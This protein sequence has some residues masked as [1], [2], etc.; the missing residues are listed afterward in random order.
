[1]D[2]MGRCGLFG[3][4]GHPR[5]SRHRSCRAVY[6]SAIRDVA[7]MAFTSSD[8]GHL[9]PCALPVQ[10][11]LGWNDCMARLSEDS[12]RK[13][14]RLPVSHGSPSAT[15][16]GG[17]LVAA[18]LA[19]GR[20]CSGVCPYSVAC[21]LRA[22]QKQRACIAASPCSLWCGTRNRKSF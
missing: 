20:W 8:H 7:N 18:R 3:N 11:E 19:A 13:L 14:P 5:S 9:A 6:C 10:S 1:M 21:L 17:S 2:I 16:G 22:G 4:F 15:L 12:N